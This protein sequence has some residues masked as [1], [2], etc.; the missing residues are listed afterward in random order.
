MKKVGITGNIG[1][2]KTTVCQIFENIGVPV[3]YADKRAKELM[4]SSD[5]LKKRIQDEFGKDMYRDGEIDR[6]KL[7]ANVFNDEKALRKL[8]SLV[9]PHVFEDLNN[10]MQKRESEKHAF[11]LE[12]AAL[13]FEAGHSSY[14]DIMVTVTANENILIDRVMKRDDVTK[15]EVEQ[16]LS[17]QM[18]QI[19]KAMQSDIIILNDGKHSLIFQVQNMMNRWQLFKDG[20]SSQ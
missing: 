1:S 20:R 15:A 5:E 2:G 9:H 7:A 16:R 10:W 3:Y 13:T 19:E 12:E 8:N 4:Q 11:A 6:K 14:F 17:R 18:P